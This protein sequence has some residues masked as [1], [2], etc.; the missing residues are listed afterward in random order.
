MSNLILAC[1][2]FLTNTCLVGACLEQCDE[3]FFILP[4]FKFCNP[5]T[6]EDVCSIFP[7]VSGHNCGPCRVS[8][9]PSPAPVFECPPVGSV[10]VIEGFNG[11]ANF[12]IKNSNDDT[13][14]ALWR[15][16]S[17]GRK[18][19]ARSYLGNGW[20]TYTGG[21]EDIRVGC[22]SSNCS[23]TIMRRKGSGGDYKYELSSFHHFTHPRDEVS[24][25]LEQA[26]FGPKLTEIDLFSASY[27]KWI[28]QQISFPKTSHRR[29]YREHWNHRNTMPSYHG[30]PTH[31]CAEGTR[32]RRYAFSDKD[33]E[34]LV[35]IRTDEV[36]R[37][38]VFLVD[39]QVRTVVGATT[40]YAG[41]P[42]ANRVYEDGL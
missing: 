36:N 1:A 42:S 27:A 41:S 12:R 25:F 24:R 7:F 8:P 10:E 26:T 39:G 11:N 2:V 6:N 40:L 21:E 16:S 38:K 30:I 15:I 17:E 33:R 32:Y 28:A 35:E 13:L 22:E 31:P 5:E 3:W 37:K 14:C 29:F 20:E 34:S 23:S 4:R 18:A 19:V 9:L